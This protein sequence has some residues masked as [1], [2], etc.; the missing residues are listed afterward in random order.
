MNETGKPLPLPDF[1]KRFVKANKPVVLCGVTRNWAAIDSWR[2]LTSLVQQHGHRTVPIEV[3]QHLSGY[4]REE[5]MTL[6][7]FVATYLVPSLEWGW[8]KK[9]R[10][11]GVG[12]GSSGSGDSAPTTPK[13][14]AP[15]E[16]PVSSTSGA[17]AGFTA[18]HPSAIAYL[19]QHGLFEQLPALT[20][21]FDIPVYAGNEVGAVNAWFGTA[22]TVTRCHYDE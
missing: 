10:V 4:W 6:R 20:K 17:P 14:D 21:E 2:D 16:T 11:I 13:P 5:P 12:E 7:S 9:I 15:A 1:R 22:G 18:V 8:G 19:A 3:G